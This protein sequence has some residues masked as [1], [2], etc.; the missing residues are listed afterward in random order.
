MQ[1]HPLQ[2]QLQ[3]V[4]ILTHMLD[5]VVAQVDHPLPGQLLNPLGQ[6]GDLARMQR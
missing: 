5:A 3:V 1:D 4:Q 6:P 2:A